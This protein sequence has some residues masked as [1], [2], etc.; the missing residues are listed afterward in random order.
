MN[1]AICEDNSADAALVYGFIREHFDKNG[2]IGDIHTFES[3]EAL[4]AAFKPGAFD[5]VFL[6]VYLSGITGMETAKKMREAD[7]YFALVFITVSEAHAMEAFAQRACGYVTKPIKE[8][9]IAV[10]FEQ[11]Q[12]VFLKNARFIQVKSDRRNIRI[13]LMKIF[14]IEVYGRDVIFH[15]QEGIIKTNMPLEE[16][17][18]NTGKPFLRCHRAYLVNMNQI[19]KVMEQDIRMK[20]GDAIPMRQR[21]RQEIRDAYAG[22]L[23][24][25]LFEVNLCGDRSGKTL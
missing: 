5:A 12:T 3:G 20:N 18:K 24:D 23:T 9:A 22:F 17:E 10:A 1:I 14:Y 8:D 15:T 21:G 6:D 25:R 13:P 7:P 16:I 11:C 19:D 4:L 2:F